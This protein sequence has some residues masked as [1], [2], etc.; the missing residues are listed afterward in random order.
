MVVGDDVAVDAINE[1]YSILHIRNHKFEYA[2]FSAYSKLHIFESCYIEYEFR[3][4][5]FKEYFVP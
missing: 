2:K 4:H 1:L 5:P 3:T